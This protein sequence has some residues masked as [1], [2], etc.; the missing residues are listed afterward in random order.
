MNYLL[1]LPPSGSVWRER[2]YEA[3]GLEGEAGSLVS[4]QLGKGP[5]T[6]F[7]GSSAC[8]NSHTSGGT[9]GK[10]ITGIWFGGYLAGLY[11]PTWQGPYSR[12]WRQ[13]SKRK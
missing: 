5:P 4:E 10:Y 7:H 9:P 8:I 12:R 6:L 11:G 13:V 2:Q 3:L 1:A